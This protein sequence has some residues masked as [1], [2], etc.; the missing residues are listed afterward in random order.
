[1]DSSN[2]KKFSVTLTV[3]NEW[4][5]LQYVIPYYINCGADTVYIFLDGTTDK[6]E[7][8]LKNFNNVICQKCVSKND[9]INI[10]DWVNDLL[11]ESNMDHRKRINTLYAAERAHVDGVEWLLS[12][13]PDEIVI[14]NNLTS[15]NAFDNILNV[16]NEVEQIL[17]P[18]IELLP[19][20]KNAID[21][22]SNFYCG[23]N[24]FI[25]RR[26]KQLKVWKAINKILVMLKIS[27]E[28]NSRICNRFFYFLNY[29]L[30]PRILISPNNEK[31][32]TAWY[33]GYSNYKS[34]IRTSS[35][36]KANFN[37]HQWVSIPGNKL[38]TIK[39][40][41]LLHYDLPSFSYYQKKF[42]QRVGFK[43]NKNFYT[44]YKLNK[45]IIDE[46]EMTLRKFYTESICVKPAKLEKLN[47]LGIVREI[48]IDSENFIIKE[49]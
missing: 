6:T 38:N 40:G 46:N 42:K 48:D 3:K 22:S 19:S 15:K 7:E 34:L 32:Y 49:S 28:I 1:M 16:D 44:R 27:P 14:A 43:I 36:F 30:F 21:N 25:N 24:Y 31:I 12:I 47:S 8:N 20:Q 37:I 23:K 10:P 11:P 2:E 29:R 33:L 41:T 18:N 45:I 4:E 35:I 5:A 13:D 9:L 26:D 39:K 17:I